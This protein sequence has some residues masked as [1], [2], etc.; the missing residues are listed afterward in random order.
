MWRL[1]CG[2]RGGRLSTIS[3]EGG[4]PS[5]TLGVLE[6]EEEFTSSATSGGKWHANWA[7]KAQTVKWKQFS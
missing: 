3:S 1:M 7:A 4:R 5:D 2:S 6:V